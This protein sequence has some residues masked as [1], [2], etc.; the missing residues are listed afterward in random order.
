MPN[1]I[2]QLDVA[3]QVI[4]SQNSGSGWFTSLNLRYAFSQLHLSGL[5]TVFAIL[6]TSM[7]N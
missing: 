4:N 7:T 2:E 6:K 1:L 5:E 3:A